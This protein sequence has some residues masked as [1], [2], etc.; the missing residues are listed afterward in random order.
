MPNLKERVELIVLQQENATALDY[1]KQQCTYPQGQWQ[2][3]SRL[4]N[5]MYRF[6]SK[7]GFVNM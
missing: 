5:K 7:P 2:I 6:C 3:S 1:L 4:K